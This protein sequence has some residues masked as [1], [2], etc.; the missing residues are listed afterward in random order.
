MLIAEPGNYRGQTMDQVIAAKQAQGAGRD[1]LD[2]LFEL[3]IEHRGAVSTVYA[4]HEER[5]MNFAL[6]QPWCSVG[7]DGYALATS[8]VLR[9]GNPHPR[10]FGTFPRVLGVY[11]REQ[12]LLSLEEGVRKITSMNA[13]KLGVYDRG[14][15]RPGLYADI[16]VFDADTVGDL[17]SYTDP[18]QYNRGIELVIV[19]GQ[20][21][22]D[23]AQHTGARSGK[24]LRHVSRLMATP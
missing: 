12:G 23:G 7:S 24:V 22:L 10:S 13:N 1:S 21:V 19:N 15:L 14:L 5:D 8:G 6:A 20:I 2:I 17:A 4:H 3:L 16:T 9:E 11:V 18:F